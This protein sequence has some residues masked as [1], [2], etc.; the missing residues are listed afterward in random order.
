[1]RRREFITG[2]A[3]G[4]ALSACTQQ[5]ERGAM[6]ANS[7]ERFSWKM[8]TAWPPNFP[9]LG[10][11]ANTLAGY[12]AELS[13]GRLEVEI[14]AA[15]ALVPALEIFDAVSSG[16]AELGHGGAYYWRGKAE[17]SQFFTT[18]PF[19]MNALETNAWLYYGGGM[20]LWEEVY[21]P[22]GIRPFAVGGSGVQMGGWLNRPIESIEDL[23]GLRM[24]LPGIGGEV[25][26][27]AG[28]IPVVIA[29]SEIFT[30]LQT[31]V[32]DATEW[33]GP[34]NDVAFGLHQAARYY[35]YPGWHEP[36]SVIE[37]TVNQEAYDSLPPDLQAV[38]RVACQAANLDMLSEYT[39]RNAAALEQIAADD[40][41]ELRRFPDAVLARLKELTHEVMDDLAAR[42]PLSAKIWDS[43]R[44]F[45][46]RSRPWQQISE[47]AFLETTGL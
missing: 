46:E 18:I 17:A 43:Y 20:E 37:C 41:V 27:R 7:E 35:Y 40:S 29:G 4:A 26:Q 22:F 42:D 2:V 24:R 34:Y 36:G 5:D 31:G 8:V 11:G 32:I 10:T 33:V 9:G 12:L 30:S 19:G 13:G 14:Y 1:M 23:R 3:G 38:L 6:I 44:I 25:L 21:R 47:Q 15:G 39:A 45:M 28:G 16:T